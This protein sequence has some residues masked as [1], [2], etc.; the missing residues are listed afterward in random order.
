MQGRERV[1]MLVNAKVKTGAK[2]F[3]VKFEN[4]ILFISLTEQP[5]NNKAN[6][7]LIKQLTKVF[8][9]CR[10]VKGLRSKNKVIEFEA[11]KIK[12]SD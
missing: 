10:I 7:E 9:P 11:D 12:F 5:E 8:G 4:N 2:K 3:S 1:I 6:I